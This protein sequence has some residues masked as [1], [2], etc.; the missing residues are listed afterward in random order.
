MT[1]NVLVFKHFKKLVNK[2]R[3]IVV[4]DW[5]QYDGVLNSA[6]SVVEL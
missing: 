5:T 1:Q 4:T 6:R 2:V 3:K